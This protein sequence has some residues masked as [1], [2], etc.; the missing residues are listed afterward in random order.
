MAQNNDKTIILQR[1]SGISGSVP[2]T[3]TLKVG[4]IGL[5]TY[6]GTAFIHKSGSAES[7]EQLVSTNS[8]TIGDINILGTGSFGEVTVIND[9]NISGSI[10]VTGD[11]VGNADLDI[12]GS[13]TASI[14]TGSFYGDGSGLTGVAVTPANEYDFNTPNPSSGF[15][16]YVRDGG[17]NYMVLPTSES[18]EIQ[19]QGTL[20]AKIS[21]EQGF[22]GS[23]YGIGDVLA[24][25]GSIATRISNLE[26]SSSLVD[27][28]TW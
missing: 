5:N 11:I 17:A 10:Y 7:I 12:L 4:E 28:G 21:R 2:T 26:A 15:V 23:L 20:I 16:G 18:V 13:V 8:N 25:S 9:V 3:S 19:Y 1:R 14:F 24:F 6:D 27:A 22:S